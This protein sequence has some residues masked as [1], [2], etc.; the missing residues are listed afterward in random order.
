MPLLITYA[1]RE[2][3]STSIA[4]SNTIHRFRK[5]NTRLVIRNNN[6]SDNPPVIA[7]AVTNRQPMLVFTNKEIKVSVTSRLLDLNGSTKNQQVRSTYCYMFR[8]QNKIEQ[9]LLHI[10]KLIVYNS[11]LRNVN[12]NNAWFA[13]YSWRNP[14]RYHYRNRYHITTNIEQ[15]F[16][17]MW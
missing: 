17:I 7:G 8:N 5:R 9:F 10:Y 1:I 16:I 2:V 4:T 14:K 12:A 15:T 3:I 6:P 13:S 11:R